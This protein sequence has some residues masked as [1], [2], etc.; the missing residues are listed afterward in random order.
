MS[1][2]ISTASHPLVNPIGAPVMAG[3]TFGQFIEAC[4]A[5]GV[6]NDMDLASIE[7]GCARFGSGR[8]VVEIGEQG[9]EIREL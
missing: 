4:R 8:M 7:Y 5:L 2:K 1:Q 6:T 3:R 9:I